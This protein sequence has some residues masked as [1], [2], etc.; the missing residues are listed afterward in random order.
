MGDN[1]DSVVRY[2][3]LQEIEFLT[4]SISQLKVV[5]GKYVEAKDNLN[6]LNKN[7][8]GRYRLFTDYVR[9]HVVIGVIG[10]PT[11]SFLATN[12]S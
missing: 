2:F 4:S 6:S 11:P 8:R 3:I 7:N 10:W 1:I 12:A 5:Q 9:L